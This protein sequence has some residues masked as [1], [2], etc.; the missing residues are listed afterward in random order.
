MKTIKYLVV[1]I[2]ILIAGLAQGQVS[3]NGAP[4]AWG[5][6]GYSDVRYYYLPD[7]EM[8][9]DVQQSNFI[10]LHD[11]RWVYRN[12]L[13]VQYKSYNLYRGYKVPLQ[14]YSGNYPYYFFKQHKVKYAKGYRGNL[15]KNIGSKGNKQVKKYIKSQNGRS[16][17]N[18]KMYKQNG[19]NGNK[20]FKGNK[21]HKKN[22]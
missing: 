9:Y 3:V 17:G 6:A 13:P 16:N 12:Y 1:C 20:S 5:P 15:Q 10:Y 18:V 21:G 11:N 4:P 8:Y 14:N 19:N 2:S 7:M 22:K